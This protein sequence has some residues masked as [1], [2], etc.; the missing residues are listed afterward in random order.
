M[1]LINQLYEL[2]VKRAPSA[3]PDPNSLETAEKIFFSIFSRYGDTLISIA[4]I[5]EFIARYP[6]VD[7]LVFTPPQMVPYF[8][9][10]LPMARTVSLRKRNPWHVVR[11]L[12][13]LRKNHFDIGYNPWSQGHESCYFI[14][15]CKYH[16]CFDSHPLPPIEQSNLYDM[17]R[18]YLLLPSKDWQQRDFK[19]NNGYR[20]ILLCPQTTTNKKDLDTDL[21]D[22][23][24]SL[25]KERYPNATL[26]I[27]AMSPNFLLD[28][29]DHYQFQKNA[30]SSQRFIDLM[31]ASD[32]VI[33]ADSAPMH[34]AT[35]MDKDNVAFF[36]STR[37][38]VVMN[39]EAR[40]LVLQLN[41]S[42]KEAC[43]NQIKR[44]LDA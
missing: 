33:C 11:G 23:T 38:E 2:G 40:S 17:I 22:Y 20:N 21:L 39:S 28:G 14:T 42:R 9:E 10:F 15:R 3:P 37:P 13:S 31:K 8:R 25:L 30:T 18:Q 26:T 43:R 41:K 36:F 44:V 5:R 1:S 19:L 24:A 4:V 12:F 32:L 16:S 7:Y 35:M 29:Y 34:L 6:G 27:A